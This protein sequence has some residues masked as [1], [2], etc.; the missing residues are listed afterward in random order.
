L[1]RGFGNVLM[2]GSNERSGRRNKQMSIDLA[3]HQQRLLDEFISLHRLTHT[4]LDDR[5]VPAEVVA[6]L[7]EFVQK[8]ITSLPKRDFQAV[9]K[10]F[11]ELPE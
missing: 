1:K 11:I 8:K 7:I 2:Q 3:Q 10:A 9:A 6:L 5:N 4:A